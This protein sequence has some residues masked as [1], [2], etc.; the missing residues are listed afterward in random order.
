MTEEDIRFRIWCLLQDNLH[1][2]DVLERCKDEKHKQLVR[3]NIKE[4]EKEIADLREQLRRTA[5]TQ[6]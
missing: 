5:C 2:G 6:V 3:E 4:T 1:R